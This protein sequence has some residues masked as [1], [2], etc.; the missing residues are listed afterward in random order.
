MSLRSR[1]AAAP[2]SSS[3][4]TTILPLT[5]W[6]PPANR[7]IEATS[8]LRQQVLVI[9]VLASSAFTCAVI[10]MAPILRTRVNNPR[11]PLQPDPLMIAEYAAASLTGSWRGD[12]VAVG[13][14]GDDQLARR[15]PPT[16]SSSSSARSAHAAASASTVWIAQVGGVLE[17]D[18]EVVGRA[19]A[20][21][22]RRPAASR[23]STTTTRPSVLDQ[24]LRAAPGTSRCGITEVN[25]EPGPSTTQSAAAIAVERLG[26]GRR[27]GRDRARSSR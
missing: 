19:E 13:D 7:S 23:L 14:V 25:H 27:V 20:R 4:S 2:V 21:R 6:R 22:S 10:A 11:T 17:Q 1:R 12:A 16:A 8:A 18:A 3:A 15:T 9:W 5:M 26:A 24:G